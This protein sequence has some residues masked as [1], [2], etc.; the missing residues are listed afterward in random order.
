[1][2]Q[3]FLQ[4][5]IISLLVLLVQEVVKSLVSTSLDNP[6]KAPPT[7]EA[8]EKGHEILSRIS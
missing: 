6:E 5:I 7:F 2:G 8:T 4:E 3:L 1:L